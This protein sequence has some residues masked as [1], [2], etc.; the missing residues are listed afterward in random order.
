MLLDD[1]EKLSVKRAGGRD[2]AAEV[3]RGAAVRRHRDDRRCSWRRPT[4]TAGSVVPVNAHARITRPDENGGAAMLR[5][6]FSFHDGIDADGA[7]DAGLLFVC[8]Q[9]DPLRGFVP[10]QRKLDRGDAL[11]PFLRHEA[12]GLFAVPG[13]AAEPGTTWGSGCWRAD[14]RLAGRWGTAGSVTGREI[15]GW[16]GPSQRPIRVRPCQPAIRISAPRAP[17]PRPPCARFPRRPPGELVPMVSVPAALDAVRAGEAERRAGADRELRRGRHHHHPRRTGLRRAADD[18]PRGAA[19]DRLRAAGPPRHELSDDEDGH[20]RTRPPSRRCATGWQTNLPDAS[21]SRRPPTRT[22]RGWC[23]RAATTAPSRASSRRR[24]TAWSR[25]STDIHD[26]QNAQTRFVLVGRPA[27]PAAPTGADKTSVVLWLRDD[28]PGALL[29]LLQEFAVRG[30]NLMRLESRPT[31]EGIGSYCFSVDAE[32]HITDRR[33][34]E[35][36]MGLKRICP[37]V[38]FLGSYPRADEVRRRRPGTS[39]RSSAAAD[40]LAGARRTRLG[41]P[42]GSGPG[43]A[44]GWSG[45]CAGFAR[46][47]YLAELSPV[48][49]RSYPQAWF[50]T[51]GQV[52]NEARLSRQ[53]ALQPTP[54]VHSP[55]RSP[56]VTPVSV[57]QSFRANHFHSKVSVGGFGRGIH[58]RTSASGMITSDFHRSFTQPVDNIPGMP[59]SLWTT[60]PS[61][62]VPHTGLE[63]TDRTP[64]CPVPGSRIAAFQR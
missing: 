47:S 31:G 45:T 50:S 46:Q 54:S 42:A 35:A 34:G 20:R 27:R 51:W 64:Q 1:W 48:I 9:A 25:W 49:H 11:S 44:A 39:T 24:R 7:P 36:L 5:R 4:P 33:V 15:G 43:L 32:G 16:A 21:G 10:V 29:E 53:I 38:R 17:S 56:F 52:D 63:S 18:L 2:R 37:Q 28:H 23:R 6:P 26:A 3:Q 30:V 62:P 40:W 19:A 41:R 8:W 13:G 58:S 12:S 22:A 14:E 55:V 57:D 61:S 60:P 59:R